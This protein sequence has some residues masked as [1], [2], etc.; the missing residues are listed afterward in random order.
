MHYEYVLGFAFN[1]KRTHVMLIEKQRPK[2]QKGLING[3]GGHVNPHE[4]PGDAMRREGIEETRIDFMDWKPFV[5]LRG[6]DVRGQDPRST[7][8]VHC[9]SSFSVDFRHVKTT[10]DE[11]VIRFPLKRLMEPHNRLIPNLTWLIPMA[12]SFDRGELCDTFFVEEK[13]SFVLPD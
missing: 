6:R 5:K 13:Y 11:R 2:W 4:D 1:P 8:Q 10:T 9:Y 7:F 3:I 12:M